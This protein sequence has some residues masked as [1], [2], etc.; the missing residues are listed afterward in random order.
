MAAA[1]GGHPEIVQFLVEAKADVNVTDKCNNLTAADYANRSEKYGVSNLLARIM[2]SNSP[3]AG[4]APA[5]TE[6]EVVTTASLPPDAR[7]APASAI[8]GAVQAPPQGK[9][10]TLTRSY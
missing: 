4:E 6:M 9:K 1:E 8:S 2:S 7:K 5:S 3:N 10:I